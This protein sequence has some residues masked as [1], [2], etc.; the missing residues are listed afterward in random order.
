MKYDDWMHP[1]DRRHFCSFLALGLLAAPEA[2]LAQSG[3]S[4]SSPAAA[5]KLGAAR[6]FPFTQMEQRKTATGASW[7]ITHG[8]LPTGETVNLHESVQVAGAPSVQLHVIQHSEFILVSEGEVEY[9][10]EV[11]GEVVVE[12]ATAG[13]VL[14]IPIGT[15]HAVRNVGTGPARYFVVG[16]GGDAK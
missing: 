8:T 13:S 6:V 9:K 15:R 10:H 11:D 4:G 7:P 5:D 3:A 2:P 12:R 14:Y 1:L 16:I